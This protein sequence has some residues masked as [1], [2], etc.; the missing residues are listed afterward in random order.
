VTIDI[1]IAGW[2]IP[3]DYRASASTPAESHLVQYARRFSCVEINSSFY[4]PHL[5]ATYE[6]WGSCVPPAFRFAAKLPKDITHQHRLVSC[7]DLVRR[8]CGSVAGLAEKLAVVLV[9]LPPSL[10]FEPLSAESV[11]CQLHKGLKAR[12]VCEPRHASWFDA[13]VDRFLSGVGVTRVF[14]DPPIGGPAKPQLQEKSF[15][16]LRLHG[17]PHTYYSAYTSRYLCDLARRLKTVSPAADAHAWCIFDNTA[18]GAAWPDALK[19]KEELADPS[20]A[21]PAVPKARGC[22]IGSFDQRI[23]G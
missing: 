15:S 14:A 7:H 8:F 20:T 2:S 5:P 11:F 13:G 21:H 9:Q 3:A 4:K 12:I 18:R 22:M 19:L 10:V 6:R 16:Y 1:G 17:R 23:D